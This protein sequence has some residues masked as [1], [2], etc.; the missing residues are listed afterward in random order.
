[1]AGPLLLCR[2]SCADA[3]GRSTNVPPSR[4]GCVLHESWVDDMW[5]I[6][7]FDLHPESL[8]QVEDAIRAM[9]GV[10]LASAVRDGQP[11]VVVECPTQGDAIRVQS[12]VAAADPAAIVV[13]TTDGAGETQELV[14]L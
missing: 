1:M 13:S 2:V 14:G 12:A 7:I 11:Y 8:Q 3:S 9:D 4:N 6:Q 10:G 5:L